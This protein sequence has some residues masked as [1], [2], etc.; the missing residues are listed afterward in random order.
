MLKPMTVAGRYDIAIWQPRL[1]FTS[2][3]V[4]TEYLG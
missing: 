4:Q 3:P 2:H 1:N